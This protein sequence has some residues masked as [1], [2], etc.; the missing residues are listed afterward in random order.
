M[1][2]LNDLLKKKNTL[3]LILSLL[4]IAYL[5]LDFKLPEDIAN[6][7]DN[8]I[9]KLIIALLAIILFSYSNPIL[10]ILALFIA[11]KLINQSSFITGSQ[12]LA[13]YCPTEEKKWS[14]FSETNQFSYT[15][16]QEMVNKMTPQRFNTSYVNSSFEPL[17]E[18]NYNASPLSN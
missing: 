16:E 17:L 9:S 7:L 12:A 14:P 3:Q 18:N 1:E 6:L 8:N 2:Y 11:Y 10:G 4:I 13:E 15:L 5:V